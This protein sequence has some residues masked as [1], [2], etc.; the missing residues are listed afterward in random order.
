MPPPIKDFD[1]CWA[2]FVRLTACWPSEKRQRQI[3]VLG[4]SRPPGHP[5]KLMVPRGSTEMKT[6]LVQ[7]HPICCC[8][9]RDLACR[10]LSWST[11]I[12]YNPRLGLGCCLGRA[13]NG[14]SDETA[15]IQT[16]RHHQETRLSRR[17]RRALFG[18]GA[19]GRPPMEL[20]LPFTR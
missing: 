14:T 13:E 4:T 2:V 9:L 8:C 3:G 1:R 18:C 15:V 11:I 12:R 17:R 20:H 16:G 5:T 6:K 19:V 7:R 10:C